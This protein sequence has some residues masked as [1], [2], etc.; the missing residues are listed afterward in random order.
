MLWFVTGVAVRHAGMSD[1]LARPLARRHIYKDGRAQPP[2]TVLQTARLTSAV[3]HVR[4]PETGR[5]RPV[6]LLMRFRAPAI[7]FVAV[8]LAVVPS[9][10]PTGARPAAAEAATDHRLGIRRRPLAG[11]QDGPS[12]ES[13][14]RTCCRGRL[15]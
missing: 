3:V 11:Q 9:T 6:S 10:S 13:L 14:H 8:T 5:L 15:D 4:L 12:A 2:S 7:A 1:Q